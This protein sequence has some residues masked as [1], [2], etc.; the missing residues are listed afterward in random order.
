M[1]LDLRSV[2]STFTFEYAQLQMELNYHWPPVKVHY[3][4]CVGGLFS[5]EVLHHNAP[6]PGLLG[7]AFP[8]LNHDRLFDGSHTKPM[9]YWCIA[10]TLSSYYCIV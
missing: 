3:G 5:M 4:I 1:H 6:L 10:V 9:E 2:R 8:V 7:H